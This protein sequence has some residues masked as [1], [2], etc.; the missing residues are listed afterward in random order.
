MNPTKHAELKRQVDELIDNGLIRE[1]MSLYAVPALLMPK[2][3]EHGI[4]RGK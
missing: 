2:K 4:C 1:S 3:M